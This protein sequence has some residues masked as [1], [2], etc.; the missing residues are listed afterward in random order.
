MA[1]GASNELPLD[2]GSQLIASPPISGG[3]GGS[4]DS[5]G[6]HGDR[7]QRNNQPARGLGLQGTDA[8]FAAMFAPRG[9]YQ[10]QA[11]V[12]LKLEDTAKF[13]W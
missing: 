9:D 1:S 12:D 13:Y 11:H 10:L 2:N 8:A 7:L 5:I 6:E 4:D 3:C